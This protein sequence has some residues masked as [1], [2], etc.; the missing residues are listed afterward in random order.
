M[1]MNGKM[2]DG[3]QFAE[4]NLGF[5]KIGE[6]EEWICKIQDCKDPYIRGTQIDAI[7]HLT[8]H[9]LNIECGYVNKA[10]KKTCGKGSRSSLTLAKHVL[11]DHLLKLALRNVNYST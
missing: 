11:K 4:A 6:Q 10:N 3:I 9:S 1:T 7:D 2:V 8:N 5:R